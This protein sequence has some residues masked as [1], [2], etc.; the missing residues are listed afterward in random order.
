MSQLIRIDGIVEL[1]DGQNHELFKEKLNEFLKDNGWTFGGGSGNITDNTVLKEE[2][3]NS[4][5]TLMEIVDHE[6]E[7][8][9][10]FSQWT[11]GENHDE[12]IAEFKRARSLVKC[13]FKV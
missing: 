12:V 11:A 9:P 1:E 10:D 2:L 3:T 13:F 5:K 8:P 7:S 4:L 6:I